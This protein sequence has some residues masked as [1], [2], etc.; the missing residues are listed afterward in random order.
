MQCPR[1]Q[2]EIPKENLRGVCT[3]SPPKQGAARAAAYADLQGEGE[4]LA[5]AL[6]EGS[7]GDSKRDPARDHR[8]TNRSPA[9]SQISQKKR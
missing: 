8:L 9:V 6:N 5:R 1:C 7:I 2:P 4:Q 3:P